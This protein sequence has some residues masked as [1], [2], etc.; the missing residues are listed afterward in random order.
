MLYAIRIFIW[1]RLIDTLGTGDN[2]TEA[3]IGLADRCLERISLVVGIGDI[4]NVDPLPSRAIRRSKQND[5]SR[6]GACNIV[7]HSR[8]ERYFADHF[9]RE[10]R[11]LDEREVLDR[12]NAISR[13][14]I[15][16]SGPVQCH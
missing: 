9:A 11:S 10:E 12:I 14:H 4:E 6:L 5:R 13:I 3:L 7:I 2:H 16:E 8:L 15:V 1:Y